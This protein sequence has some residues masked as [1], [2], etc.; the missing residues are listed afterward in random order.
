[1][2]YLS[3]DVPFHVILYITFYIEHWQNKII[4]VAVSTWILKI[5]QC[6]KSVAFTMDYYN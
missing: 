6:D 4:Y 2:T 5:F 3:Y 1:M